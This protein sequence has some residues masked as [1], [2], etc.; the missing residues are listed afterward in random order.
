MK[1]MKVS[2]DRRNPFRSAHSARFHQENVF[3]V[4]SIHKYKQKMKVIYQQQA[5]N[6]CPDF[7]PSHHLA[8]QGKVKGNSKRSLLI[9]SQFL[10]RTFVLQPAIKL[11]QTCRAARLILPVSFYSGQAEQATENKCQTQCHRIRG[12]QTSNVQCE[13]LIVLLGL[14]INSCEGPAVAAQLMARHFLQVH[15]DK[16]DNCCSGFERK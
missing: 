6:Q 1:M 11:Y 10:F 12:S 4:C 9:R 14:S 7:T 8:R 13:V 15:G 5:S 2:T 3:D 16:W